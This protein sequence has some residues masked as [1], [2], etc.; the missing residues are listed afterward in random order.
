MAAGKSRKTS[1]IP[2][3]NGSLSQFNINHKTVDKYIEILRRLPWM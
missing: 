3:E 1:H 2:I